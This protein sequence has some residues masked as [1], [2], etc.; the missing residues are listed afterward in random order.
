MRRPGERCERPGA[1][2]GAA[3]GAG[4]RRRGRSERAAALGD[5]LA[6]FNTA[7][8]TAVST[9]GKARPTT[10][11]RGMILPPVHPAVTTFR[12]MNRRLGD[13][14]ENKKT[15]HIFLINRKKYKIKKN[16]KIRD[17]RTLEDLGRSN[18]R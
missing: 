16:S 7:D 4:R 8:L 10:A 6:R 5:G 2:A 18:T 1:R 3:R 9:G 17:I 13:I 11:H 14:F 12:R 15:K